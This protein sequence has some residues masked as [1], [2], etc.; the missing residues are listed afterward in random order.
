[1]DQY[2]TI[3]FDAKPVEIAMDQLTIRRGK[4]IEGAV[5]IGGA[6]ITAL[7]QIAALW[8]GWNISLPFSISPRWINNGE[9]SARVHQLLRV[10]SWPK[11]RP[12]SIGYITSIGTM[13]SWTA[14]GR[15]SSMTPSA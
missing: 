4:R 13:S 14:H 2:D 7:P 15:G 10:D 5:M 8:Q 3:W 11:A 1:M 9:R 12:L 6:K